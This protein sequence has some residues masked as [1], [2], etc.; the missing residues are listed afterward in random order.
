[1]KTHS[2]GRLLFLA[3]ASLLILGR[4]ALAGSVPTTLTA[5]PA[6]LGLEPAG[7][8]NFRLSATLRGPSGAPLAGK[9]LIF[10]Y[11]TSVDAPYDFRSVATTTNAAGTAQV[12]A[13]ASAT[14]ILLYG[15]SHLNHAYV[16]FFAG[17]DVYQFSV[18]DGTLIE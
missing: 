7:F 1:M 5:R 12:N 17:D 15:L 10:F 8:H 13:S 18:V 4:S 16:V 6:M 3:L 11:P 2:Q 14:F 9:T